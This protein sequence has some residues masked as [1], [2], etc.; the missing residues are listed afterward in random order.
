MYRL[1]LTALLILLLPANSQAEKRD[2]FVIPVKGEI[3]AATQ[4]TLKKGLEEA[5]TAKADFVIIHIN[6]YGGAVDAVSKKK[7]PVSQFL[8]DRNDFSCRVPACFH[9][10]PACRAQD[11]LFLFHDLQL[12]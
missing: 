6:T 7:P 9:K 10:L 2:I 5:R 8:P 12:L 1:I 3:S 11:N 4:R